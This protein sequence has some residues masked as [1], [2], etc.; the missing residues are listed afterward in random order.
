MT[1]SCI[2]AFGVGSPPQEFHEISVPTQKPPHPALQKFDSPPTGGI[3]TQTRCIQTKY[4]SLPFSGIHSQTGRLSEYHETLSKTESNLTTYMWWWHCSFSTKNK[5]SMGG[6][7]AEVHLN[8]QNFIWYRFMTFCWNRS[9]DGLH[10][11]WIT[12]SIQFL[13]KQNY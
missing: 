2:V 11:C 12:I 13:W 4:N 7:G 8:V 10:T 5:C 6:K 1:S 9:K 3:N